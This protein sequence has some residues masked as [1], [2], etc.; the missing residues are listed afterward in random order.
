MTEDLEPADYVRLLH[1]SAREADEFAPWARDD[2]LP[3]K[4][5]ERALRMEAVLIGEAVTQLEARHPEFA[6]EL[7]RRAPEINWRGW[8]RQRGPAAH[9]LVTFDHDRLMR[10]VAEHAPLLRRGLE[11]EFGEQLAD[12]EASPDPERSLAERAARHFGL[13]EGQQPTAY[14]LN[15]FRWAESVAAPGVL[16]AQPDPDLPAR[17]AEHYG[18]APGDQPTEY[19]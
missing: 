11:R 9:N 1:Q 12:R 8:K 14:Q 15:T 17:A 4:M 7:Q 18:L 5:V 13:P 6:A 2:R 3:S 19:Q 16:D 10:A